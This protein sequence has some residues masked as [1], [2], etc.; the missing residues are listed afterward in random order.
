MVFRFYS[1][2]SKVTSEIFWYLDSPSKMIRNSVKSFSIPRTRTPGW[3]FKLCRWGSHCFRGQMVKNA[4]R[5]SNG[6]SFHCASLCRYFRINKGESQTRKFA[7]Q[8]RFLGLVVALKSCHFIDIH[9]YCRQLQSLTRRDSTFSGTSDFQKSF[10]YEGILLEWNA[11][12]E[13]PWMKLIKL[14]GKRQDVCTARKTGL[15]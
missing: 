6:R 14:I 8:S 15:H 9:M 3:F 4:K 2:R 13:P 12:V 7:A 5:T 10:K 11:L 1:K